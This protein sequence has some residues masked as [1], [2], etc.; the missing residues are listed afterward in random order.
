MMENARGAEEIAMSLSLDGTIAMVTG[1]GRGIGRAIAI[2]FPFLLFELP[3]CTA[4]YSGEARFSATSQVGKARNLE[5]AR[6]PKSPRDQGAANRFNL[7]PANGAIA[8]A[9]KAVG[10]AG[11]ENK[12]FVSAE[13]AAVAPDG[14]RATAAICSRRHR[15]N[16]A[17]I[18]DE[19]F[20]RRVNAVSW[21]GDN[22]LED[23]PV[24]AAVPGASPHI[25]ARGGRN[26]K[27]D[28]LP[29]GGFV[30]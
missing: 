11:G 15:C 23:V 29:H 6:L 5:R 28:E 7:L 9:V 4:Q 10:D 30:Q 21:S 22:G 3:D 20:T 8:T 25:I 2:G 19:P 18:D 27:I 24:F 13:Y 17:S 14:K 26:A 16:S 12:E 1:G